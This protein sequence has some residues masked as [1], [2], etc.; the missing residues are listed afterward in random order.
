MLYTL[1]MMCRV[2]PIV[3][4]LLMALPAFAEPADKPL[5][6]PAHVAYQFTYL[7][8][9]IGKVALDIVQGEQLSIV[10]SIE[11]DGVAKLFSD[12]KNQL[13]LDVDGVTPNGHARIF[14]TRYSRTGKKERHIRLNYDAGGVLTDALHEGVHDM[15]RRGEITPEQHQ[16]AYDP[17]SMMVVLREQI[18]QAIQNKT[19]NFTSYLYDGKRLHQLDI[20]IYGTRMHEWK[21]QEV[22]V[23]KIG[24]L[25][26]LIAGQTEKEIKKEAAYNLPEAVIYFTTE[27]RFLPI[28]AK[29]SWK[30]GA[31]K[32]VM[33]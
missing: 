32:A 2:T 3:S 23:Q 29:Q 18:Y 7:E 16:A 4:L 28:Y 25:R 10:G 21:G 27:Q 6:W 26:R 11:V 20:T 15:H 9:P 12:H 13:S 33:Q 30:V 8:M 5:P 19:P 17:L 24:L 14:D 22:M 1:P 31:F